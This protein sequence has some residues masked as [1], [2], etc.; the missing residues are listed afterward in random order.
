V[1]A[2]ACPIGALEIFNK[3]VYVCDLCGGKP[4]CIE[5]CTEGAI[6]F[7]PDSIE[8]ISLEGFKKETAQMNPSE[9]RHFYLKKIGQKTRKRRDEALA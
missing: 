8:Q 2:K 1:C 6:I 7:D 3:L 9:R 5:A 4:K